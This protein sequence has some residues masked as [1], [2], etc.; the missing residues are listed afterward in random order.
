MSQIQIILP[1]DTTK[2]L[3]ILA[4]K[5]DRSLKKFI[6]LYLNQAVDLDLID[7]DER[8]GAFI[9]QSQPQSQ[10]QSQSLTLEQLKNAGIKDFKFNKPEQTSTPEEQLI[11]QQKL[12]LEKQKIKKKRIELLKENSM[13]ILGY[14][15]PYLEK[16]DQKTIDYVLT[17]YPTD[18]DIICYLKSIDSNEEYD[19]QRE[20]ENLEDLLPHPLSE[21]YEKI[22]YYCIIHNNTYELYQL[23]LYPS[24]I[25]IENYD[26][27]I[28]P[29]LGTPDT[30]EFNEDEIDMLASYFTP[31]D[32]KETGNN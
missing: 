3:K 18:E 29:A 27:I 32:T 28:K 25:Q 12:D 24:K 7:V 6:P 17:K 11:A 26:H 30:Y 4:T 5:A 19:Y 8:T 20:I 16:D 23:L 2:K 1:E 14:L 15:L 22:K 10:P 9:S 21:E 31:L 13:K